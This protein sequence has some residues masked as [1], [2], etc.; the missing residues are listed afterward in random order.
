MYKYSY[1]LVILFYENRMKIVRELSTTIVRAIGLITDSGGS[2]VALKNT[3]AA[4]DFELK[5][6]FAPVSVILIL[7]YFETSI[8]SPYPWPLLVSCG[9]WQ[10]GN[11]DAQSGPGLGRGLLPLSIEMF[12]PH[13]CVFFSLL[14]VLVKNGLFPSQDSTLSTNTRFSISYQGLGSCH[15][16]RVLCQELPSYL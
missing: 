9:P 10:A 16:F 5:C 2:G 8:F 14:G 1:V 4:F 15:S 13:Y 11:R 6:N 3:I 7:S 12:E